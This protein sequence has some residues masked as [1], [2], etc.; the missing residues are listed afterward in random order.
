MVVKKRIVTGYTRLPY[1]QVTEADVHSL[2]TQI[3]DESASQH[4]SLEW[5]SGHTARPGR[6]FADLDEIEEFDDLAEIRLTARYGTD[7]NLS[8]SFRRGAASLI[9]E[10]Y[11]GQ[12]RATRIERWWRNAP[13]TG[14][15]GDYTSGLLRFLLVLLPVYSLV[16]VAVVPLPTPWKVA[17]TAL[18]LVMALTNLVL[19]GRYFV[20]SRAKRQPFVKSDSVTTPW[21]RQSA[22]TAP[23]AISALVALGAVLLEK[24]LG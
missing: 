5:R 10:G 6:S 3:G 14:R 21:W 18:F 2:A 15:V 7:D 22:V 20:A 16:A 23:I 1:R 4:F 24:A 13:G 17:L 11:T 8:M 12:D 9:W 19:G